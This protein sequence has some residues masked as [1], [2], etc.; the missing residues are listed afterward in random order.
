MK[1][2][3][4]FSVLIL[5]MLYCINI[6]AAAPV[7]NILIR[8]SAYSLTNT[9]FDVTSLP[10]KITNI[11]VAIISGTITNPVSTSQATFSNVFVTNCVYVTNTIYVNAIS[12][13]GTYNGIKTYKSIIAQTGT[14]A[15]TTTTTL[16]NTLGGT[17]VWS[18]V[19][20]GVYDLTLASTFPVAKTIVH[21]QCDSVNGTGITFNGGVF[22]VNTVRFKCYN[23]SG[24]AAQVQAGFIQILVY[25]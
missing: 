1:I 20:A 2:L 23:S 8:L 5:F 9:Q 24:A 7:T 6:N 25:P 14:S 4:F 16:E 13:N 15:P 10:L 17:P 18:Y 11:D 22:D 21:P 19:S 3:K 12:N